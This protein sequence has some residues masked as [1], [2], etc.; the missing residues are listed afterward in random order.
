MEKKNSALGFETDKVV[1]LLV[2]TEEVI[3]MFE[4]PLKLPYSLTRVRK[5][6]N[7]LSSKILRAKTFR[8]K[9]VNCDIFYFAINLR[10][11][12]QFNVF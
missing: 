8:I 10:R 3:I 1:G 7:F 6:K 9:C 4:D 2:K 5:R 12:R 11:T